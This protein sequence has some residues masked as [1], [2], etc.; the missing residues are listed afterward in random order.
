MTL[1]FPVKPTFFR[2][3]I[4]KIKSTREILSIINK[5][6]KQEDVDTFEAFLERNNMTYTNFLK[7]IHQHIFDKYPDYY[8]DLHKYINI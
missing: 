6:K 4:K 1:F 8:S 3:F 2:P 7:F 5:I